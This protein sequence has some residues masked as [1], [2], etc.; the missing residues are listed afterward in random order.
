MIHRNLIEIYPGEIR[1]IDINW[2]QTLKTG[3]GIISAYIDDIQIVDLTTATATT[4]VKFAPVSVSAYD[5]SI[6]TIR[7][8]DS[9]EQSLVGNLFRLVVVINTS[10]T[11]TYKGYVYVMLTADQ[12]TER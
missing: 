8:D 7:I 9:A 10:Y 12:I 1:N 11:E 2:K 3:D 6:M 4:T 5:G